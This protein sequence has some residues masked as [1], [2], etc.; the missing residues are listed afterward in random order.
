M[1]AAATPRRS[2]RLENDPDRYIRLVK[3]A[4]YQARPIDLM[5]RY[6]LGIF[7]TKAAARKA[8]QEFWW[9]RLP[10]QPQWTK[11]LHTNQGVRFAALVPDPTRP[12]KFLRVGGDFETREEAAAAAEAF[13]A[14]VLA[15]FPKWQKRVK[16]E[17]RPAG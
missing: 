7:P 6:D 1:I 11:K 4:K 14:R 15:H 3:G 10:S 2:P 13:I 5:C 12:G 16:A 8:I 17:E 9:G